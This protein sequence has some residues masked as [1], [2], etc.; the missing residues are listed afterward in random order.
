MPTS[1][2]F[3][4]NF[5]GCYDNGHEYMKGN[6]ANGKLMTYNIG[7][8]TL[9]SILAPLLVKNLN[10]LFSIRAQVLILVVSVDIAL[11]R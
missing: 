11:V 4:V 7:I 3:G 8:D 1:G 10:V 5:D 2:H 9:F 6:G